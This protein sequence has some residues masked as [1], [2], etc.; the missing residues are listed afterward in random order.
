MTAKTK[1]KDPLDQ[2]VS[3]ATL[4]VVVPAFWVALVMA[5]AWTLHATHA[6]TWWVP[7]VAVTAAAVFTAVA[8]GMKAPRDTCW[9][10]FLLALAIGGYLTWTTAT[11][12]WQQGSLLTLIPG[13]I[14]FGAWWRFIKATDRLVRSTEETEQLEHAK[15][16]SRGDMPKI[17]E[18]CG[19]KGITGDDPVPFP[20]AANPAGTDQVLHLPE[21]GQVSLRRLQSAV[22]QVEIACKAEHPIRFRQGKTRAQVI[23]RRMLRDVLAET[24]EYPI[25]RNPK[26]IHKPIPL[27]L[28]EA[29]NEAGIVFREISG[30]I[31]GERGSGKS[32]AINTHLA[33]LTGCTDALVWMIDGKGGRTARPWL[34]ALDWVACPQLGDTDEADAM[35]VGARTVV[36]SRSTGDGEKVEPSSRQPAVVLIIEESSVITGVTG[37]GNSKRAQWVQEIVVLGR[38]EAVDVLIVGQR[39]TVTILGTG[40]MMSQLQYT[41]GLGISDAQ[42][43][44]RAFGDRTLSQEALRYAGDDRYVGVELAKHP[45]WRSPL[46]IKGYL[47]RPVFIPGLAATNATYKPQLEADAVDTVEAKLAA[48]GL[49]SYAG[50]WARYAGARGD[51]RPQDVPPQRPQ[52]VAERLGLPESPIIAQ[53]LADRDTDRDTAR[54]IDGDTSGDTAGDIGGDMSP[55]AE[56]ALLRDMWD[57]PAADGE[58]VPYDEA[59][60]FVPAILAAVHNLFGALNATRLHTQTILDVFNVEGAPPMI[61]PRFGLLMAHCGVVKVPNAF[62]VDGVTGRGYDVADVDRAIQRARDGAKFN[63]GAFDWPDA[64]E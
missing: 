47:I 52:T 56:L 61:A 14:V 9:F 22:E 60:Q 15:A 55:E 23:V 39:G 63:P 46:P 16:V 50:R 48:L 7:A 42:D 24:I 17:L 44:Q 10:V 62:D 35:I 45:A 31:V 28:D 27:G 57:M 19:F 11:T 18:G 41:L 30:K 37:P 6:P 29:G 20:D 26:T 25:D 38:S 36:A 34:P 5:A 59:E 43:A 54:D 12:P 40:D 53:I 3:P 8:A 13:A 49:P 58:D 21:S 32:A 1:S 51:I 2:A 33:Y 64:P 4:A